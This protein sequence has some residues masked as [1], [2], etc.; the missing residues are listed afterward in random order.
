MF[1]HRFLPSLVVLALSAPAAC[2]AQATPPTPDKAAM[3][4]LLDKHCARCHQLEKTT[5]KYK[6]HP[7]GNFGFIL[8]LTLRLWR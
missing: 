7:A 6:D 3:T 4:A 5:G 8:D 2:L 1:R